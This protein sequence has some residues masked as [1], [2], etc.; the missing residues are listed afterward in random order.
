MELSPESPKNAN[1]EEEEEE[2]ADLVAALA[3]SC[4]SFAVEEEARKYVDEHSNPIKEM[5][6]ATAM[7]AS[8]KVDEAAA[9]ADKVA[10]AVVEASSDKAVA[11]S[12]TSASAIGCRTHEEA[13]RSGDFGPVF[14]FDS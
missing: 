13:E 4:D 11:A 10:E 5:E 7:A 1:V 14:T 12:E 3:A 9:E 8:Q 2:D 6:A